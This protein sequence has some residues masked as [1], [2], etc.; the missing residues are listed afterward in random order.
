MAEIKNRPLEDLLQ[1]DFCRVPERFLLSLRTNSKTDNFVY[2]ELGPLFVFVLIQRMFSSWV[3]Q[4][5]L[6]FF[7]GVCQSFNFHSL[8]EST[9]VVHKGLFCLYDEQNNTWLLVGMKFLF[10]CSTRCLTRSRCAHS[11]AIELNTRRE[12]PHIRK[13]I[14]YSLLIALNITKIFKIV[15]EV[16]TDGFGKI[17]LIFFIFKYFARILTVFFDKSFGLKALVF[18]QSPDKD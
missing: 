16:S 4:R 18:S 6:R 9:F 14:N 12:I 11:W 5:T 2:W 1:A 7:L 17:H 13:P 3:H 15:F 8:L 10:S